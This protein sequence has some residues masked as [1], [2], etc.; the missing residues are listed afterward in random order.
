MDVY[1][2]DP[3]TKEPC[4][5][6]DEPL[7]RGVV[8]TTYANR[9]WKR[10]LF[11]G[12]AMETQP[13]PA[14]V[15]YIKQR[16]MVLPLDTDVL[17]SIYPGFA[18]TR[19]NNILWTK[20]GERSSVETV[21]APTS[22]DYELV[23]TAIVDRRQS[24]I[25]PAQSRLEPRSYEQERL[26]KLPTMSD[27][28]DPLAGARAIAEQIVRSIPAD[29]HL[30]RARVLANYLRDPTNFRYSLAEI[31]RDPQLDP[32]EDF[33]TQHRV[34]HCEY[35]ARRHGRHVAHVG[36]PSR[37][38][39]GFKGGDWTGDHYQVRAMNAHAWVEAY[40]APELLPER[41]PAGFD[42]TNGAWMIIDPTAAIP[43]RRR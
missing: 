2:E 28:T 20:D 41:L 37:L 7:F 32:V 12:V 16:F 36:I 38:T 21:N 27:G 26:L 30:E 11:H 22:I 42:R 9:K 4:E 33:L 13:I 3:V 6:L 35:F 34:G 31:R 8:L 19:R 14:G 17:F 25:V 15:P 5:L 29:N 40:L 24:T 1:L 23:T 43:V 18:T 10:E 39:I